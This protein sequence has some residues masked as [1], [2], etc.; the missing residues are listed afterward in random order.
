MG[1]I[2][3][4][5]NTGVRSV[6][7]AALTL[8]LAAC[9]RPG[10]TPQIEATATLPP[11]TPSPTAAPVSATA[12]PTAPAL[13][14]IR[15]ED[16][17]QLGSLWTK[18]ESI[19]RSIYSVAEDRVGLF[20][21][22]DFEVYRSD[23]LDLLNATE[24]EIEADADMYWYALSGNARVGAILRPTGQ[25]DVYNLDTGAISTSIDV[26]QPSSEIASDI[27]INEAGTE[28]VVVARLNVSRVSIASG[29][30]IRT[31]FKLPDDTRFVIFA[32]DGARLAAVLPEGRVSVFDTQTGRSNDLA[33]S[34]TDLS[35]LSFSADGRRLSTASPTKVW[36]W[37]AVT[38]REVWSLPDLSEPV[39]LAFSTDVNRVALYAD[40]TLVLFDIRANEP[41]QQIRLT[42]GGSVDSVQF[43]P[44]GK[45]LYV[46][47]SGLLERFD[48]PNGE[49]QA[50]VR[51][52]AATL[53]QF[54]QGNNLLAWSD[55]YQ[56]GELSVLD[57]SDG[58]TLSSLL[59]QDPL[60]WTLSGRTG[61]YAS[62]STV[63]GKLR[64]WRLRD[65]KAMLDASEAAEQRV[66][67]C[68]S[69]DESAFVYLENDSV[70]VRESESG[71]VR[72][73]FS[74][75]FDV[76]SVT[77]CQNEQG[78][79]AFAD[80][81]NVEVMNI[82]GRTISTIKLSSPVT[83]S[84]RLEISPDGQFVAGVSGTRVYVWDTET[85][86]ETQS[87][88]VTGDSA[89]SLTFAPGNRLAITYGNRATLLDVENGDTVDL[90]V[91]TTHLINLIFPQDDRIVITSAQ[92]LDANT[93]FLPSGDPNFTK[94][95]LTIWNA[96]TGK[97]LRAI[98]TDDPIYYSAISPDGARVATS[99][100]D[101]SVTVWGVK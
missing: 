4:G 61:A 101:G 50:S 34:V 9:S 5:K 83:T 17:A 24:V 78:L 45:S 14:G 6:A 53:M 44:D 27:A 38:G 75:P 13:T 66:M 97:V 88:A 1:R 59:H 92:I 41:E 52:F 26:P 90:E 19:P 82:E 36:V 87:V 20:N 96:E 100:Y 7:F 72:K 54:T 58:K 40:N 22:R 15:R 42:S 79:M 74:T 65:G 84:A 16:A 94:G 98:E 18:R 73:R 28:I 49:R 57:G 37:D 21:S 76:V 30:T 60:R 32:R 63:D 2:F 77:Y 56:N 51:R 91:P 80:E 35:R 89:P 12:T 69:P 62:T 81:N 47:G 10:A 23:D 3:I 71:Q 31:G 55:R 67:L 48:V 93:P 64:L 68:V 8:L 86:K 29:K 70:I 25:L 11:R 95:E 99:G 85:G 33:E 43:S 39:N 46:A